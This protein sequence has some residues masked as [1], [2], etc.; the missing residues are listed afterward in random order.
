MLKIKLA[1]KPH[2]VPVL[3]TGSG[4]LSRRTI[5]D[6]LTRSTRVSFGASNP[7]AFA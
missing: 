3:D 6:S 5:T 1:C 7:D 2:S 4:H